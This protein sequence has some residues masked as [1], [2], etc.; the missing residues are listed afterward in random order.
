MQILNRVISKNPPAMKEEMRE[1]AKSR[2]ID[3]SELL[4]WES[5]LRKFTPPVHMK[6]SIMWCMHTFIN[7]MVDANFLIKDRRTSPSYTQSIRN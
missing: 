3:L 4:M 6:Y 2:P 5:E 7:L 1:E